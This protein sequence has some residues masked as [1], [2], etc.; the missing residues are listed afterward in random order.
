LTDGRVIDINPIARNILVRGIIAPL[1]S[2]KS[3]A[4]YKILWT[5]EGSPLKVFGYSLK[6]KVQATLG[7]DYTVE[8]AMRYQKPSIEEA[9]NKLMKAA[10]SEIVVLPLFPH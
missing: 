5:K 10:V 8:L 9:L 4:A 2:G 3:A 7:D 6:D 1:R